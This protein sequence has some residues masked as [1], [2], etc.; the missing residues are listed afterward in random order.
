MT[1]KELVIS[2]YENLWN[3]QDK[4]YIDKILSDDIAFHGSLNLSTN[5]KKEFSEYMDMITTAIPNLYHGIET[6]VA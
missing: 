2:Y 5:G 1:N 3:K 6:I 4:S